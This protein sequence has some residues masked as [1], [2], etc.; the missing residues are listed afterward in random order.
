M[1]NAPRRA[2]LVA[3][4][5]DDP[6]VREAVEGLVRSIGYEVRTFE[7]AEDFLGSERRREVNCII[8]DIQMPGRS[9]LEL[10]ILL[11][12]EPNAAP[13]IFLTGLPLE[14]P[15]RRAAEASSSCC[16][17]K[18]VVPE[19]LIRCLEDALAGGGPA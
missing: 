17:T 18:P 13:I 14:D 12:T 3:V 8:A 19:E 11:A 2:R 7:S 10:Q 5:D 16:L 15:R 9:G 1:A 6:L 4:V